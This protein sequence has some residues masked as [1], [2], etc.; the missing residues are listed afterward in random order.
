MKKKSTAAVVC[1]VLFLLLIVLI[2]T[3]DV[4]AVGPEGTSIGL[5]GIN[6]AIHDATGVKMLWSKVTNYLGYLAI[7]VG[8]CFA[9]LG[10]LQLIRRKSLRKVDREIY[11]LGALYVVLAV[12]YALFEFV[13]VNYR[14]IIMPGDAHVEAA[15][16]SSHT[17]L[18]FVILGSAMMVIDKYLPNR[19]LCQIA[20]IICWVII[21]IAVVGRLLSGV[22]WFTDIIGG[23]ILGAFLLLLFA[24]VLD[25]F[26]GSESKQG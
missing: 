18:V 6:G 15:F 3:V 26:S 4:A 21:L 12:V 23:V 20:K 13:I 14:P 24:A 10:L 16:P 17:V 8:L 25:R 22:H 9:L 7:L 1:L 19:K 5:S 2:K 11:A